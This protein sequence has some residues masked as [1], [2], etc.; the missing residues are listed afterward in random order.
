MAVSKVL[1]IGIVG[2]IGPKA[3]EDLHAKILRETY[4]QQ[5]SDHLPILLYTNPAI[6]DRTAFLL[7]QIEENPGYEIA[8]SV[9]LLVTAGAQVI[10]VPCNTAHAR[11]IWEVVTS[12]HKVFCSQSQLLNI[13]E[14][15]LEE[16]VRQVPCV[17]RVG[18]LAT[19]GTLVAEVY[20]AALA[21]REIEVL[22]P[23]PAKQNLL[24]EAI[25]STDWGI[26]ARSAPVTPRAVTCVYETA[27]YLVAAGAEV[28]ILGCTELPLAFEGD[29]IAGVP[30]VDSTRCLARKAIVTAGGSLRV[31]S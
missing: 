23:P 15:T 9:R 25:Y 30:V 5:D 26:K 31:A 27:T 19:T 12:E 14:V 11:P 13:V 1:T 7:G 20:Q 28:V 8:R 29:H 22:V 16:V 2:G 4:A 17:Q 21:T 10:C 6:P 3:G 24:H 18:V